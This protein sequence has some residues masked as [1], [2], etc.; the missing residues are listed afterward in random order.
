[1][2]RRG[3]EPLAEGETERTRTFEALT[4]APYR[5]LWIGGTFAFL[6]IQ[7]QVVARGWLALELTGSNTGLGGVFVAFGVPVLLATPWG[8]VAADRLPKRAVLLGC[9]LTLAATTAWIAAA[10]LLDAVSYWMLVVSAA[11]QAVAFSFLGP[12]RMA[13]TGELV[14]R[15]L[16]TNAVV[17]SQL[18]LNGT[19]ILGP[20]T[21]GALIGVASIG[22]GGVYVGVTALLVIAASLTAT[23][24]PGLPHAGPV[25]SPGA[26]LWD[27]L[28]Y[29]RARPQLALLLGTSFVVVMLAF[30]YVAF[31]PSLAEDI[32]GA[33]A[34][35]YG[36]LSAASAVGAFLAALLLA[37]RASGSSV[38]RLQTGAG[39]GFGAGL[40]ALA[41]SP[42]FAVAVVVV[43]LVGAGSTS[44]QS[45]NNSLAL[46]ASEFEYHGRIQSMMMLSFGG[47][48]LAAL[49]LGLVAD[50][51]GLRSTLAG[52]GSA[53][54]LGMAVCVLV[55]RRLTASHGGGHV[56]LD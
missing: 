36:L 25:R 2:Q 34:Q 30:P 48:G 3:T 40:V 26:E 49:P 11:I 23:L 27:G 5:R 18:S 44:F 28:R 29:V 50:A 47:F 1:M 38:W 46:A 55:E 37:G 10:V 13:F 22:I 9:Q 42:S 39:F 4:L 21:A 20:A 33:G 45:L 56:V 17:L 31:L 7:A 35:G 8:G 24:P 14:G 6:G 19:R 41:I 52:M 43:F 32:F 15:R 53:A 16:L 54:L 51:V 12:A